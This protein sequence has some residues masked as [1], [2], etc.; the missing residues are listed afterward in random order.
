MKIGVLLAGICSS[1]LLLAQT[2]TAII[3]ND[4]SA[5]VEMPQINVVAYTDKFLSRVPGS[6]YVLKQKQI[7]QIAPLSSNDILRKVPG[8][9]IVD[10][11]GAGLRVNIGIRGLDPDRS[12]N[13]LILEDGIPVALNPYGEPEMYFTPVI[14]K[15]K[16]VEVLKGSGQILFGPQTIGG[17]VNY[18]TQDPPINETARF[19]LQGGQNGFFSGYTSYGK[20]VE[21]TGFIISYL[22]KR[23]D[24]M[25]YANYKIHDLNAKFK[26]R[27]SDRS[28]L[29]IKMGVYD[30]ISNS[31]YIGLT[32]TMYD[33]G[34][35]D[36]VRMAPDDRLPV[37]RYSFSATHQYKINDAISLQ[38]TGFA[39]TTTRNW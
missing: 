16:S 27:L 35:Q 36:Y 19:K 12:R 26:F 21:N 25:G 31:T 24:N 39:Y 8:I 2:K 37:R 34:D 18:I 7:R 30:E 17:V 5:I 13:V 29:G 14:D 28:H 15:M 4:T 32:Q 22:H 23:A 38:T 11:E 1:Q 33:K 20:T 10:E 9:N 3:Q 6:V